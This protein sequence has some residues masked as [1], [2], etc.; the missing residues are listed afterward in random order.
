LLASGTELLCGLAKVSEGPYQFRGL[1]GLLKVATRSARDGIGHFYRPP[2]QIQ[3]CLNVCGKFA[4]FC[5]LTYL[6]PDSSV[7]LRTRCCQEFSE[8]WRQLI[9]IEEQLDRIIEAAKV[10]NF[11]PGTLSIGQDTIQIPP[12]IL[13]DSIFS[14][15]RGNRLAECIIPRYTIPMTDDFDPTTITDP[16]LRAVVQALMNQVETLHEQNHPGCRNPA[17]AG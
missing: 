1:L 17:P 14:I 6:R 2:G 13:A 3:Q 15:S 7:F 5:W 11:T 9:I 10:I 4:L 16:T 12:C 8:R